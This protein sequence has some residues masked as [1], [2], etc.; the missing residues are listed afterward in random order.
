MTKMEI[1]DIVN[2]YQMDQSRMMDILLDIHQNDRFL[3]DNNLKR[4]SQEMSVSEIEILDTL[5]FYHFFHRKNPGRITIYIDNSIIA[6]MFG[7]EDVVRTF[8]QELGIKFGEVDDQ[9]GFG[10]FETPCIGLSDQAP[11]AL[12]NFVPFTQLTPLKVK[13]IV[14]QLKQGKSPESIAKQF[15]DINQFNRIKN[16]HESSVFHKPIKSGL[17]LSLVVNNSPEKSLETIKDS[18]LRGRGGAGFSTGRK[19]EMCAAI[20]SD[21][22][23]IVCN[24]DEG[25]PG[26]FKDRA[27]ISDYTKQ[28]IEGMTIAAWIIGADEG[29]IYLRAEYAYLKESLMSHIDEMTQNQLLGQSILGKEGFDFSLRVQMGA[30]SYVCGEESALLESME[31]K[32]GE[33][34]IRPPFP[35]ESG[36]HGKPTIINNVETFCAIPK[37]IEKGAEW[38]NHMG[39]E[40]STGTRLISVSG[41]CEN[42]GIYEVECGLTIADLLQ[43]VN[44]ENALALQIGGPSGV[45]INATDVHRQLAFEDLPTGGSIMIFNHSRDLLAVVKNFMTFFV[46]ESCGCCTPCRAGNVV[47][48]KLVD[49]FMN[50]TASSQDLEHIKAWSQIIKSTS[51]CGLGQTSSQP[52]LTTY[53]A[54]PELFTSAINPE[55]NE[56]FHHFDVEKAT[57]DYDE[58]IKLEVK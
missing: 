24:A 3:D 18:R 44:A 56:L 31:G 37:I 29:I 16:T 2:R 34:R 40:L 28:V 5:T 10:L 4:L 1:S 38:F 42:S 54:F 7:Q 57:Q 52:I 41:D 8:E 58:A 53:Q 9:G 21:K 45:L 22:K 43:L 51:R 35:I 36:Y 20:K 48:E 19:W 11:A 26:T 30:G 15:E 14:K 47:L 46:D 55:R 12:I 27:L 13:T 33:P 49:Q 50:K 6:K 32:R 25:E 17:A 23:Y 39:T